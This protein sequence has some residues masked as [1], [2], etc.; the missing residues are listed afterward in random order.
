MRYIRF[1]AIFVFG[2]FSSQA[3]VLVS[4]LDDIQFW[5]GTGSNRAGIV[6]DWEVDGEQPASYA[7]GFRWDGVA[8]GEDMIRGI[9]AAIGTTTDPDPVANPGGDPAVTL[10]TQTFS[11]GVVVNELRYDLGSG[12]VFS[13]GG[14]E[15]EGYWSYWTSGPASELPGTWT[16]SMVGMSDRTLENNSWDGWS[17]AANF[18]ISA[19][20]Q[21]FAAIPEPGVVILLVLG[22]LI[23]LLA[24]TALRNPLP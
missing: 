19:P 24:R 9:A 14:F 15:D 20:L 8:T 6:I 11:F 1:L 18:S 17:W 21:P 2:I 5:A 4:S 22:V 16:S 7:W 23:S 3:Q 12:L 13:A 10:W